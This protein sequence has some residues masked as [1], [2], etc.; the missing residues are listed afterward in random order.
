MHRGDGRGAN[1][2]CQVGVV[3][4]QL[5]QNPAV[6]QVI[7]GAPAQAVIALGGH[8]LEVAIPLGAQ[9]GN[10]QGAATEVEHCHV[11]TGLHGLLGGIVDRSC[12]RL[13]QHAQVLLRHACGDGAALQ[14]LHGVRR[15]RF[16]VGQRNGLGILVG[17][18]RLARAQDGGNHGADDLRQR[19]ATASQLNF[20]VVDVALGAEQ[21]SGRVA[22]ATGEGRIA[23]EQRGLLVGGGVRAVRGIQEHGR[24]HDVGAVCQRKGGDLPTHGALVSGSRIRGTEVDRQMPCVSHLKYSS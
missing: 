19:Q 21:Q 13:G 10:I 15:P 2:V 7:D 1:E 8:D 11:G 14:L 12:A 4:L 22:A 16:G 9:H 17:V 24:R 3:V 23:V 5:V 20:I 18:L 6:E